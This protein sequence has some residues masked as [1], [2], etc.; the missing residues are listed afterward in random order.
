MTP[1]DYSMASIVHQHLKSKNVEF[2]LGEAVTGFEPDEQ[3]L[4]VNLKS[5]RRLKSDLVILSIGVRPDNKLA[6]E[7]GLE[8]GI[9]NG[10]KVNEHL[11]TSNPDVYAVG[12]A[13]EFINPITGK[14]SITYLA[15]PANK[16]GRICANN[17]V[18]GNTDTYKGAISTAIAKVFDITVASTAYR[19]KPCVKRA[20]SLFRLLL[21]RVR[22]PDTTPGQFP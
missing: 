5:G 22:T 8:I 9:T 14:P 6:K 7:A 18:L 3:S 2:Y 11:Q 19:E 10:I 12:D 15:G 13:I 17:M 1:L 20:S 16:Q 21:T 4:F